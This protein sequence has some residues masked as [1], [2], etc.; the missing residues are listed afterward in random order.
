MAPIKTIVA[1]LRV[2]PQHTYRTSNSLSICLTKFSCTERYTQLIRM[3]LGK[4]PTWCTILLYVFISILYMFR[5]TSCSSSGESI[6]SIQHLVYVTLCR[7]PFRVQFLSD[8]H[9][10]RSPTQIDIYQRMYGYNLFSWWWARGCSKRVEN[11]DK[12][13]FVICHS[14]SVTVSFAIPFRPAHETVTDTDW[15]IPD[16][17]WIQLILLM[18]STGLLETCREL[19]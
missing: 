9:T 7:W 4:W 10:K 6:V 16:D 3:I 5:A 8:L 19:K 12:Y 2:S 11:W 18:I 14:V 1:R 13:I 17:V 15:H